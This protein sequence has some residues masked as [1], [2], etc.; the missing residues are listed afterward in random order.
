M[1]ILSDRTARA[2]LK[3][4]YLFGLLAHGVALLN[5]FS[6]HDELQHGYKLSVARAVPL[7]RWLRAFLG[8]ITSKLFGGYNLS[9]PLVYGVV[10]LFFIALSAYLII[11]IFR[12]TE[13]PLQIL[14]CGILVS[15]PVVT[16][17]FGYMFTAP[18]YFLA[19]FLAV[20]AVYLLRERVSLGRCA[21][22]AGCICCS[23][24]IYQPYVAVALSLFVI[25]MFF[26][27]LKGTYESFGAIIK[28]GLCYVGTSVVGLI[29]YFALWKLSMVILSTSAANYQGM[30]TIGQG[31]I[32]AYLEG[33]KRAYSS[34]FLNFNKSYEDIY[35]MSLS[36]VQWIVIILSILAGL[37]LV[38]KHFKKKKAEG[39]LLL[40][41]M[42]ILPLCLN[43]IYV[44][45]ASSSDSKIH[46]LMLY[47]QAMLYVFLICAGRELYQDRKKIT[48]AFFSVVISAVMLL[49]GMNI[50]LDNSCYLKGEVMQQ[51]T[52]TELTV[53]VSRIKSTEG[54]NDKMPVCFIMTGKRDAT[55]A[56]N[57]QFTELAI[58]PY[59]NISPYHNQRNLLNYLEKWCGFSPKTV[60]DK[61][62]K[63]LEEVKNMPDYPDDGDVRIIDGT[64]VI[65]W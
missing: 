54:Y 35:P 13:K 25:L 24:G 29:G 57:P 37:W 17:T 23:L 14:L 63:D 43:I 12:I 3:Y 55:T 11:K 59:S 41:L 45:S 44:M 20:L 47:G 19:L 9:L 27:I 60:S 16:S 39:I 22:S 42:L 58:M 5:K 30:S 6:W 15:F 48:K 53:L 4:T 64:V 1:N 33:I 28:R 8:N 31:G 18:Y 40:A 34:F 46:S 56:K 2:V 21:I 65:K 7:G 62:F 26:D 10:S 36:I 49:C 51:Q 32:G 61:K 52:I 50:Y 38:V